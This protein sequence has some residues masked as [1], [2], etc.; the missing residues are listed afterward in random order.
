MVFRQQ[1]SPYDWEGERAVSDPTVSPVRR[2]YRALSEFDNPGRID[3]DLS[4]SHIDYRVLKGDPEPRFC[5]W[6]YERLEQRQLIEGLIG[7]VFR[8]SDVL[9]FAGQLG[10]PE[11]SIA[12]LG[13]PRLLREALSRLGVCEPQS[14]P[15]V[16]DGVEVLRESHRWLDL[17][18]RGCGTPEVEPGHELLGPDGACRRAAERLLKIVTV[19]CWDAGYEGAI[20][21]IVT[22]GRHKFKTSKR[23]PDG[24]WLPWLLKEWDLGTFNYLLKALSAEV[25]GSAIPFARGSAQLWENKAFGAVNELA[26][27]LNKLTHD[28]VVRGDERRT[29]LFEALSTVLQLLDEEVIRP[30]RAVQFCRLIDDGHVRHYEGYDQN[31]K[32]LQC[33]ECRQS[34]AL[35]RP[36]LYLSATNPSALDPICTEFR[37]EFRQGI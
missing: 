37:T 32:R 6:A 18:L 27:A 14:P 24:D 35:H 3:E 28:K 13:P 12:S 22:E 33:F 36:Y 26:T 9:R 5:E 25:E 1:P 17:R 15:R 11:T 30:P 20:R 34:F 10:C 2:L 7:I 31:D 21:R 4:S 16:I 23:T 29:D 19:F 8:P